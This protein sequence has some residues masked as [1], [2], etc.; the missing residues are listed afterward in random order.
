MA[1]YSAQMA[2]RNTIALARMNSKLSRVKIT[3]TLAGERT[4]YAIDAGM[5]LR[6][7]TRL[8]L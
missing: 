5:D 2:V 6:L 3:Q 8:W 4:S 7:E 1:C